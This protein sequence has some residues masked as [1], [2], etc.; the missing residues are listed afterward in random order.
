[1]VSPVMTGVAWA[2]IPVANPQS[3][4][5]A[6]DAPQSITLD[7]TDDDG[8]TLTY[9]IVSNPSHGSISAG[10]SATRTYTPTANYNGTDS[11]TFKANDGTDDS[12]TA[13]VSITVTPVNDP[14]NAVN[15]TYTTNENTTLNDGCPGSSR[16]RHRPRR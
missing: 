10:T 6:E 7:A 1:M 14:P 12:N 4:T 9:S 15:N 2:A 16:E 8:D 3:V 13:T 5:T 11:F